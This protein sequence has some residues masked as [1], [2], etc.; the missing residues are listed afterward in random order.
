MGP[1]SWASIQ[2]SIL[3]TSFSDP[4]NP[5]TYYVNDTVPFAS[6][7]DGDFYRTSSSPSTEALTVYGKV[8]YTWGADYV[9]AMLSTGHTWTNGSTASWSMPQ[10][11]PSGTHAFTTAGNKMVWEK[12]NW[13][14]GSDPEDNIQWDSRILAIR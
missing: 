2:Y 4:K 11:A 13:V 1:I 6:S 5:P 9:V 10:L 8:G 3:V 7:H 12:T 14:R